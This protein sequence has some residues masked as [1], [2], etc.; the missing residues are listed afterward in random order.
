MNL[1]LLLWLTKLLWTT[2][3]THEVLGLPRPIS[4]R[5][6]AALDELDDQRT[7][8]IADQIRADAR[9]IFTEAL[10][11]RVVPDD[12]YM[13]QIAVGL[14]EHRVVRPLDGCSWS[15]SDFDDFIDL[16]LHQRGK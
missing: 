14:E 12:V 6:L 7:A 16:G 5:V 10:H 1:G 3:P 13:L 9:Q 2:K 15:L 4:A 8:G 11:E